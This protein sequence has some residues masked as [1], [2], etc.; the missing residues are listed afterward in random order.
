MI[1]SS[2]VQVNK[3][4]EP[5]IEIGTY[6]KICVHMDYTIGA[7]VCMPNISVVV[8]LTFVMFHTDMLHA[9]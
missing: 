6:P 1:I 7:I 8:K 2:S 3:D 5:F 4:L 9:Q